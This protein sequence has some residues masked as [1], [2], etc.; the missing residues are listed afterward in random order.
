[1]VN[2]RRVKPRMVILC[3][4]IFIIGRTVFREGLAE[5]N[6]IWNVLTMITGLLLMLLSTAVSG[7]YLYEEFKPFFKKNNN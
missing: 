4:A 1:M 7:L 3:I 5:D 6:G 2:K